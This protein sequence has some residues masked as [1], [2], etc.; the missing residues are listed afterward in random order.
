MLG[1]SACWV[2]EQGDERTRELFRAY[3]ELPPIEPADPMQDSYERVPYKARHL[4]GQLA[5]QEWCS[6]GDRATVGLGTVIG[7]SRLDEAF[8]GMA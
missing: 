5:R 7:I 3:M 2:G 1:D 8:A 6:K 4:R